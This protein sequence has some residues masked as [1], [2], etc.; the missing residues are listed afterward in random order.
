MVAVSLGGNS[1]RISSLPNK[2]SLVIS[3]VS[4]V[5]VGRG[6]GFLAFWN[7]D[8]RISIVAIYGSYN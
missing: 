8:S 5:A 3:V 4:F 2:I 6:T 7:G 1:A